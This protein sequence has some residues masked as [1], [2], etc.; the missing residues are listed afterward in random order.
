MS[1]LWHACEKY[2]VKDV[3]LFLYNLVFM[4]GWLVILSVYL[5][6]NWNGDSLFE[7]IPQFL[8][9][10][11]DQW[12]RTLRSFLTFYPTVS[13]ANMKISAGLYNRD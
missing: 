8:S 3:T 10:E 2:V 7:L 11:A 9:V 4:S 1:L 5:N 6:T 12:F 13:S